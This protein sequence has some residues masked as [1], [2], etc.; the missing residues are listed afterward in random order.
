MD[1]KSSLEMGGYG[2][3]N[4]ASAYFTVIIYKLFLIFGA[5]EL[6]LILLWTNL[7]A[8]FFYTTVVMPC[9]VSICGDSVDNSLESASKHVGQISR[10]VPTSRNAHREMWCCG[11]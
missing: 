8:V 9:T 4:G 7:Y 3:F 6:W 5:L 1:S 2:S 10:R 11:D